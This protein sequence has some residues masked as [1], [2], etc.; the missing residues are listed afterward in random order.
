VDRKG[1][2]RHWGKWRGVEVLALELAL[3]LALEWV[4]SWKPRQQRQPNVGWQR[5][6][7]VVRADVTCQRQ[8]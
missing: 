3:M 8:N 5:L 1:K 6:Q 7:A 2:K 4:L